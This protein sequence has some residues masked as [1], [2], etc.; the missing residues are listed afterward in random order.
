MLRGAESE[1]KPI[2]DQREKDTVAT[3]AIVGGATNI[4]IKFAKSWPTS[5]CEFWLVQV[6]FSNTISFIS[7]LVNSISFYNF[8]KRK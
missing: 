7:M 4:E 1:P 6:F 5:V 8:M 2:G 3:M